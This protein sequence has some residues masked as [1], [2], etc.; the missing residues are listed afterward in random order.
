[1]LKN[2]K[3]KGDT[4]LQK[5]YIEDV[6]TGKKIKNTGQVTSYYIKIAIQQSY[7]KRYL[8]KFRRKWIEDQE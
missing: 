1:M 5:T 7:Q 6:M 2:E 8:I 4:R 3:Y